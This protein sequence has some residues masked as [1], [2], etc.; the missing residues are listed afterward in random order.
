MKDAFTELAEWFARHCN[1]EW[2]H[3]YGVKIESCDNPGWWVQ[4]DLHGTALEGKTME[5]YR[6]GDFSANDPQPPWIDCFVEDNRFEGA[7]DVTRLHEIVH[8]FLEW[9][10]REESP[11]CQSVKETGVVGE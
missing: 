9:A 1:G 7:G 5:R 4:I 3:F 10:H 11:N 8:R 2:E 6:E